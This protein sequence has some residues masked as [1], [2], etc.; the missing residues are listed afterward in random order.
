M[1]G[2]LKKMI[3]S[4]GKHLARDEQLCDEIRNYTSKVLGLKVSEVGK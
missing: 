3:P 4:Y 2:K 1:A